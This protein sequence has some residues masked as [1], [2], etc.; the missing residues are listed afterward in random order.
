MRGDRVVLARQRHVEEVFVLPKL[1]KFFTKIRVVIFP[2]ETELLI[3]HISANNTKLNSENN[4]SFLIKKKSQLTIII[5]KQFLQC[6]KCC[7]R[8]SDQDD[9]LCHLLWVLTKLQFSVC[10]VQSRRDY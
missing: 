5:T 2:G 8:F 9:K 1:A 4:K 7:C 6:H 10:F 3:L